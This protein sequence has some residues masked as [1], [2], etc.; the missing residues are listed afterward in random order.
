MIGSI[1]WCWATIDVLK[2]IFEIYKSKGLFIISL[3]S[4]F[5]PMM[6]EF[7]DNY[8]STSLAFGKR[9]G[10]PVVNHLRAIVLQLL[11]HEVLGD[12]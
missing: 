9:N 5:I 3:S 8:P 7:S 6:K 10:S 11:F 4:I 12:A 1:R 2:N